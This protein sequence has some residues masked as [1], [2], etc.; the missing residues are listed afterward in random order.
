M[1]ISIP[2]GV[3]CFLP[4]AFVIGELGRLF[5][6]DPTAAAWMAGVGLVHFVLG[7]FC[8][9][10]AN[11]SAGVNLTAPVI[12]LQVVVTLVL[13]VTI[14]HEPC[15]LL[16]AIGGA[17]IVSGSL[18]TQRQRARPRAA[19]SAAGEPERITPAFVPR[20]LKGYGFASLTALAYGTSPIMARF[21]LEHTG[22]GTGVLGGLIAYA[23]ATAVVTLALLWPRVRREVRTTRRES[24]RWFVCSG[25]FVAMAQGFFFAAVSV[26]PI[27][28]VM[29]LLQLSLIFRLLF[30]TWLNPDHEVFGALVLTGVAVS[31]SGALM[32]SVD[33]DLIL[34]AFAVPDAIASVLRWR[35]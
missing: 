11:Q 17:L 23:A 19:D 22:P 21:A 7:R 30:S 12:Q 31:V 28:L 18:V 26:A 15:T 14:L 29:P 35:V 32:V 10:T 1:A 6:F 3:A 13:A 27:L 20:Q 25:I 24:A 16:Q 33:T 9:Y 5:Q 4:F 34:R 2:M 8:N